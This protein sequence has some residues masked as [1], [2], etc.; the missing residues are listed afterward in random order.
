[1]EV[2]GSGTRCTYSPSPEHG[3]Q[4]VGAA[5]EIGDSIQCFRCGMEG[6][7]RRDCPQVGLPRRRGVNAKEIG[8]GGQNIGEMS[9]AQ[10]VSQPRESPGLEVP[11]RQA[12]THEEFLE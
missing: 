6:Y 10:S 1:M 2:I 3:N 11:E 7:F 8:S 4:V 12:A 9:G 5:N